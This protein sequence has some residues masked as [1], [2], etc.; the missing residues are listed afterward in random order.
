MDVLYQQ[1]FHEIARGLELSGRPFLWVVRPGLANTDNYPDGFLETVEK[2][3]KIVTW[4]PQHRVL[5]HPAV[6]CGWN[7]VMKGLRNGLPFLTWP[8]FADQFIDESYVCDVWKTGLRLVKDTGGVGTS[9]HLAARIENLLNDPA[10][11]SRALEL[12]QVASRS[13]SKDG[14]STI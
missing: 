3:G 1:H 4:S 5:A 6:A 12:Q 2:Q 9:K 13:I 10:N 8:Y 11:V 7:S 14:T